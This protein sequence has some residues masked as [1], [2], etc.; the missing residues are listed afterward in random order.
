MFIHLTTHSAY[1]L[2][3]GLPLPAELAQAAA[4]AAMPALG[5]TDHRL[6]SGSVEFVTA[7]KA[8]GVQ[9]LLGLEIDLG[10][11]PSAPWHSWP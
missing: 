5:L 11:G 6:L 2:Q 8:L 7:C 1:S 10:P 9:P 4:A 3:E